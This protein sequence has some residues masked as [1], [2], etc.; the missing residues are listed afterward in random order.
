MLI[1][2][3]TRT[4]IPPMNNLRVVELKF[5]IGLDSARGLMGREATHERI[6]VSGHESY[7]SNPQMDYNYCVGEEW[8]GTREWMSTS[9]EAR[10]Q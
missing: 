9:C 10:E 2:S 3:D 1:I 7:S 6:V 5:S 4:K 8:F